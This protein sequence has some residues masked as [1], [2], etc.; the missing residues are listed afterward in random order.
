[1]IDKQIALFADWADLEKCP[2]IV[3]EIRAGEL[4]VKLRRLLLDQNP[5]VHLANKTKQLRIRFPMQ[6]L[7][8]RQLDQNISVIGAVDTNGVGRIIFPRL[9]LGFTLKDFLKHKILSIDGRALSVREVIK[10]VADFLGGVHFDEKKWKQK[11]KFDPYSPANCKALSLAIC[12]IAKATSMGICDLAKACS[13]MPPYDDFLCHYD[14]NP[15]VLDFDH[16]KWM[17][18]QFDADT[19][20]DAIS[21]IAVL[22]LKPQSHK[23]ATF[24]TLQD[25]PDSEALKISFTPTGDLVVD[26]NW[27]GAEMSIDLKDDGEIRPIGKTVILSVVVEATDKRIRVR[28]AIN[29]HSCAHESECNYKTIIPFRAVL[30]ADING[31]NGCAF[32]LNE[33]FVLRQAKKQYL[34]GILKYARYRYNLGR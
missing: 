19:K 33:M 9:V 18:T 29:G 10:S 23:V 4:S 25:S 15:G 5:L 31:N 26:V 2:A 27:A 12:A 3:D 13:P 20:C 6:N 7:S 14:I 32:R 28:M 8:V 1:M 22:E 34:D 30:G 16:D 21:I 17:D 11:L 24:Y